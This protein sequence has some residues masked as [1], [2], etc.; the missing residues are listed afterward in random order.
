MKVLAIA[1]QRGGELKSAALEACVTAFELAGSDSDAAA[2]II[3]DGISSLAE[4]LQGFGVSKCY[5]AEASELKDYH[6]LRYAQAIE[7]A[8]SAFGP[9]VILA[10]AT[11]MGKDILPRLAARLGAGLVT[12]AVQIVKEADSGLKVEKPLYAGKAIATVAMS[13]E[14]LKLCSLRPNNFSKEPVGKGDASVET[15]DLNVE[16]FENLQLSEVKASG[17]AGKIDLTEAEI[18]VS[19]GRSLGSEENFKILRELA[20]KIG[21]G[22]GASRAAVD[23]G[24]ASH[25]M[26]VGQ[27]GKTVSPKLYI[28]CGISGAIQHLAG[29]RTSSTIVAINQDADAPIFKIADY[30]V[31]GDL[32]EI[33]PK[34]TAKV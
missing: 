22:V 12:D 9:D 28:A 10:P 21:A 27:T 33:V 15:L 30:G 19:G 1:E 18:I 7:A 8:I 14:G 25:D 31:V 17:S 24:Y 20:E 34:I 4:K 16:N 2:L 11:P 6:V 13:G 23:A 5:V 3:G 32:F 26:Q 29:M